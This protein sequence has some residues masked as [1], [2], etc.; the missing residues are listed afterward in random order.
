MRSIAT[1][2]LDGGCMVFDF[3][4]TISNRHVPEAYDYL[5]SYPDFLEWAGK[6]GLLDESRIGEL[7]DYAASHPR[8]MAMAF[9]R[10][11]QHRELLF[12]LFG[13][14]AYKHAPEQ[15]AVIAY[16]TILQET[17]SHIT[18]TITNKQARAMVSDTT[19][20]LDVPLYLLIKQAFDLL[21]GGRLER[22]KCC[23]NCEWLFFDH[24]KNGKRRWCNMQ[25]CGSRDKSKRYYHKKKYM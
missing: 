1:L 20:H 11:I 8:K 22:I 18:I 19:L 2:Q 5:R 12:E 13:A 9:D 15:G 16:N 23:S 17:F 4:N 7:A 21:T 14:I 6:V 24:T 3:V 10:V 25:V